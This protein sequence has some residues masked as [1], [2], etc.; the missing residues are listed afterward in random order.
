ML[1][2]RQAVDTKISSVKSSI[3]N[4]ITVSPAGARGFEGGGNPL[5]ADQI[6]K[7][8]SLT[9]VASVSS[10]LQDRL[11]STTTSLQ[12]AIEAGSI[13]RR[14]GGG[15]NGG[16]AGGGPAGA[17]AGAA[18]DGTTPTRTFT[19]P[20]IVIGVSDPATAA[21]SGGGTVKV[22]SGTAFAAG[23]ADNVA[24]IGKTLATKNNLSVG[25][26]FTAYGTTVKVVAIYDAG[27][28]FSNAGLVM[29]IAAV[30]TL[31]QQPGV[32]S[33]AT[34]Q[35]DSITNL[36]STTTAIQT[37]LGSAADVTNQQDTSAQALAPLE[38]IQNITLFS[39]FGAVLAGA[40]IILLTMIMIVRER[41]RE[42]GILKAI[43]ASNLKVMWQF[44]VES[45]TLTLMGAVAGLA[46]GVAAAG[47]LTSLLVTTT[48][49]AAQSAGSGGF[50]GGAGR[51]FG[52][53]LTQGG[54]SIR[55]VQ[56]AVGWDILLYGL[57]AAVIIAVV[58]SAVPAWFIS[59][60]RPAEVMRAE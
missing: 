4:I 20:V 28:T 42:I 24:V 30:Q 1:V 40:V 27:N 31:S 34:V 5:T 41:R 21:L 46:L 47:P 15:G 32:I 50:G 48:T 57:L 52:R 60:V 17:G 13:G 55:T 53:L 35:V 19:P 39:L 11:D 7:I 58:G 23:S 18:P 10:V 36:A 59:K 56:A 9:H 33:S 49:S 38:S 14:F 16:A 51:G 3:G 22:T 26:T 44:M 12:S 37:T 25:S 29:P 43:G 8:K 2:A 6:A 45:I 54:D